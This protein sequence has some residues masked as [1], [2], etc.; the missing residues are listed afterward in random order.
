MQCSCSRF[1]V[2]STAFDFSE[3]E[4][5]GS[6]KQKLKHNVDDVEQLKDCGSFIHTGHFSVPDVLSET[7]EQAY[8]DVRRN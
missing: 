4:Q 7:I 1:A 2:T 3:G 5:A 8:N 6:Y